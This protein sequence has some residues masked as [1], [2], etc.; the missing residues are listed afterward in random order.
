MTSTPKKGVM[1][2]GVNSPR[3][4]VAFRPL[5]AEVHNI[6]MG[7]GMTARGARKREESTL[8]MDE[9]TFGIDG[10]T[11]PMIDSSELM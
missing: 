3:R 7:V 1:A 2:A 10:L 6:N 8:D 11:I 9:V 5:L 4:A